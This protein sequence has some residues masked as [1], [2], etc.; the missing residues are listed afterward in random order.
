MRSKK[1]HT[2]SRV[3]AAII[4]YGHFR[5]QERR[6]ETAL[7]LVEFAIAA[8]HSGWLGLLYLFG[9]VLHLLM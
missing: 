5:L 3:K 9:G 1:Q 2:L 8:Q 4:L 7:A 6:C